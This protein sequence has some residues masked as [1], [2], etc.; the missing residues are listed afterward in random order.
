[1]ILTSLLARLDHLTQQ[2]KIVS[3][4]KP[5]HSVLAAEALEPR[6][7][8]SGATF[9]VTNTND[10]GTGSL[11]EAIEDANDSQGQDRIVFARSARGTIG[12]SSQLVVTDDLIIEG[13]GARKLTVSGE[14][15][16]RVFA[17]FPPASGP[18]EVT[19]QD[20]TIANGLATEAEPNLDP[21]ASLVFPG[22]A[23]GGGI[24]NVGSQLVVD[25]V[26]MVG[27]YSGNLDGPLIAAGGAIANE[28][29]GS[30][31]IIDSVFINNASLAIGVASGG[32]ITQ[33]VGPT[34]DGLG[35]GSPSLTVQHSQFIHN[36]VEVRET[37]VAALGPFGAFA[38]FAFGGA[39]SN[40]AGNASIFH[41]TFV[42]NTVRG[43]DGVGENIGGTSSAGAI[44]T[45]DFSPFI[46]D[47]NAIPGRDAHLLVEHSRFLQNVVVAGNGG[48]SADGGAAN[49]GAIAGSVSFF[50]D[51]AT[52]RHS[53]FIGNRAQAGMGGPNRG[54]GGVATGGAINANS[55]A[56][57]LIEHSLFRQNTA[58]GGTGETGG[59]G[60]GGAIGLGVL[61]TNFKNPDGSNLFEFLAPSVE[62]HH[63]LISRNVAV[64]GDCLT[65]G[66]G[67]GGALAVS[68]GGSASVS[69]SLIFRNRAV[70]G[71]TSGDGLGGGI[72]N[73]QDSDLEL[74]RSLVFGNLAVGGIRGEGA[75]GGV[76]NLGSIDIIRAR[77]F[78]NFASD[79]DDNFFDG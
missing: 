74:T 56:S 65:G 54:Q 72:S 41:T 55:G 14:N 10:S 12:L 78:A 35:T 43:G 51:S 47:P 75:G 46:S 50:P 32:A 48:S 79:S 23:F 24:Y 28:F 58:L 76:N 5:R 45:D 57:F 73:G 33:D 71:D 7:L 68:S 60:R 62:I 16:T 29:G 6:R 22:F 52:I 11:R 37:N 17:I 31:T 34:L 66:N 36:R 40:Y 59:D 61:V 70:G 77:I 64:G 39:I 42:Q 26:R 20:I 44:F 63:S 38:G 69:S 4:R 67:L 19:F 9:E 1:M 53:Q 8:L 18:I 21:D 3:R 2:K 49:G 13:P 30:L 25:R 15:A 27:N